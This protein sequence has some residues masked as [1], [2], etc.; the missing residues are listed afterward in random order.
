MRENIEAGNKGR[1]IRRRRLF[2]SWKI[3][4]VKKIWGGNE[5]EQRDEVSKLFIVVV[6]ME[7]TPR[8]KIHR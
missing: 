5:F 2:P 4:R 8:C 6:S 1:N 3:P 7:I